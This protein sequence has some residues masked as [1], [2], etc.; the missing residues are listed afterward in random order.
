MKM[1]KTYTKI[2]YFLMLLLFST[3][4]V[5]FGEDIQKIYV[6]YAEIYKNNSINLLDFSPNYGEPSTLLD[7]E[8][9]Y[10][11]KIIS[12]D[13]KI[14]FEKPLPVFF[15]AYAQIEEE[16]EIYT[17]EI[18]LNKT[19]LYLKLPYF[20]NGKWIEIY[21]LDK[22]IFSLDISEYICDNDGRCEDFETKYICENDCISLEPYEKEKEK[23][24]FNLFN[25]LLIILVIL[26]ITTA[27]F[28][29]IKKRREKMEVESYGLFEK[30]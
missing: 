4:S 24:S 27:V 12:I 25:L 18:E 10:T 17:G 26:I 23:P 29:V 20:E 13:K 6:F 15:I 8:S 11:I 9:N 5:S 19:T 1:R 7:L 30:S 22:L 28:L 21:Y 14:L 16:N 2:L 3:I